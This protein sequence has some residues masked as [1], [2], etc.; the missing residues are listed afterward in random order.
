MKKLFLLLT[1]FCFA[2]SAQAQMSDADIR[3][4]E[5][6][7]AQEADLMLA[8]EE[9]LNKYERNVDQE[10]THIDGPEALAKLIKPFSS[11]PGSAKAKTDASTVVIGI[12]I[13]ASGTAVKHIIE[14]GVE[15]RMDQRVLSTLAQIR[16]W[17]PAT[18][19]GKPVKSK[20]SIPV[21]VRTMR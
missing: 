9:E 13:D 16:V 5:E 3:L 4:Q 8:M 18:K 1:A 10:A 21:A 7:M 11:V 17:T 15:P 14:Q 6:S 19:N 12:I 20:L 2:L